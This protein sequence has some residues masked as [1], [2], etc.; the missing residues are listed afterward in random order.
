MTTEF[1]SLRPTGRRPL[2][3]LV[4]ASL[5]YALTGAALSVA[6]AQP[7][8]PHGTVDGMGG[9]GSMGP[10]AMHAAAHHGM[11]HGGMGEGAGMMSERMLE[12]AGASAEQK[13]RV[14][15]ILKAVHDE[16]LKQ[17]AAGLAMHQQML[18]LMTAPQI[19]AAAA[20]GLR[21]KME[22]QHD[23]ASKRHL[24][25]MLDVGAVLTP[26]QRQ[27]LAERLKSRREMMDRHQRER[28]AIEP[29]G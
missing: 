6:Q 21:Q 22:A 2:R 26:E 29:K 19:D 12:A 24:Q 17:R 25:A 4:K 23:A 16:Q 11:G 15:E 3:H 5:L 13:A 28:Q 20:E 1:A 9:M 7:A 18:A 10:G 14:R 27:K 8:G